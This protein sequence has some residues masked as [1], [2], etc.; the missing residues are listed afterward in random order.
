MYVIQNR[1][2]SKGDPVKLETGDFITD[3]NRWYRAYTD[4]IKVFGYSANT[5]SMYMRIIDNF[6]EYSLL[7]QDE[8]SI[9]DIKSSYIV[10][11]LS[12]LEDEA[13][14]NGLKSKNLAKSSKQSY[15]KAIK[16]FFVF[17]S[18]NNDELYSYERF[19]KHIKVVDTS[20]AFEKIDYLNND[21]VDRFLDQIERA[22]G[23]SGSYGAYRNALL[24]KLMLYG[25]LRISEALGVSL[26]SFDNIDEDLMY[27]I[28][29]FAKGG[30]TQK[31]YIPKKF[32][33]DELDYF[34]REALL[35]NNDPIMIT[36]NKTVLNRVN[37]YTIVNRIYAKAMV[38]KT[39]LHVLR[40]T[41]AMQLTKKGVSVVDVQKILRHTNLNTTTVYAKATNQS[42]VKAMLQ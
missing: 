8:M 18:D 2:F 39:G 40:H 7:Y 22:K 12:Y 16:G 1:V 20:Q 13:I 21:E 35:S 32:I 3:I 11:F 24:V 25:G 36:G 4:H 15:I 29:I 23:K 30:K 14:K 33:D 34:T 38:R 9:V 28:K 42:I 6:I 19:F 10:G 17:I 26:G 5:I 41:C 27:E 37:A 31:A